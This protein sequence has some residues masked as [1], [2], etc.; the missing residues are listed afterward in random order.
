[1]GQA[2]HLSDRRPDQEISASAKCSRTSGWRFIPG[3]K[4][5]VLGRN[6][7]GKSTL[8]RIMAGMDKDFDGE[9]KLTDGFTVGY[10]P[11][12]PHAQP[13]QGRAGQRRGSG[14]RHTGPLETLRRDQR[15]AS[16]SRW[17]DAGNGKAARRAGPRAGPDRRPQRL[18]TRPA[19]RNRHGRHAA[20]R[21]A[22]PTSTTLSGGERRRVALCKILL[23]EARSAAVGRTDE[24]PRRRKR[25]LARAAL[26]ATMRA[27]SWP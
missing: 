16:A 17:S 20:C 18:G 9:A 15:P 4:I 1:M 6:G 7:S 14:R 8:L 12:E 3:A 11:Q 24:P 27:R 5:G 19:D 21:R 23:R 25:G 26:G 13:R 2:I 10:V 22:M